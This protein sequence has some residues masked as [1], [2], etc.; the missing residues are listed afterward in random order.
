MSAEAEPKLVA[1]P[2]SAVGAVLAVVGL[3][4]RLRLLVLVG[5][6]AIGFGRRLEPPRGFIDY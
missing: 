1:G 6:L 2:V 3:V 5:G 4:R